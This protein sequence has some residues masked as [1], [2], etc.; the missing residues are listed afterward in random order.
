MG[1]LPA[2]WRRIARVGSLACK[3][4]G[5]RAKQKNMV[6]IEAHG[7]IDSTHPSSRIQI[8]T[9]TRLSVS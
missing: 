2:C 3:S 6:W 1:G 9:C 5:K 4:V 7:F 8:T